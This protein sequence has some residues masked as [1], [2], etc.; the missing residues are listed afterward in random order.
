M[1]VIL[2]ATGNTGSVAAGKLLEK[3][4]KV[5]AI[6][7]NREK[8]SH[9]A[10]R[11]AE[12]VS[13]DV[14]DSAALTKALTGARAAYIMIPPNLSAPDVPA[15]QQQVVASIAK[16]VQDSRIPYVV[17]LSSIGADKDSKTGP[18]LGLHHL[19][20]KLNAIPS[21]NALHLRAGYFMENTLPQINVV[22]SFGML[23][24]PVRVDLPLSMIATRDIGEAAASALLALDF[25]GH[26]T[27]ELQGHRDLNYNEVAQI[28]GCAIGKPSLNY[29]QLPTEQI[30]QAM[31]QMGMSNS[32]ATQICELAAALDSGHMRFLD[33]RSAA[34]TTP[35]SFETF[36]QEVWLPASQGKAATA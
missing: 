23:A 2:G 33:P 12:T 11:G 22:R 7:R 35:T 4:Q 20:Q 5:R 19:E 21:L 10:E 6:A 36:V 26:Q 15:Y 27:R 30:V 31:T 29:V 24:G 34:N 28:I 13:A 25:S 16:A 17:V 1:Y 32:M 9:F 14:T 3:G 18:V 8:L